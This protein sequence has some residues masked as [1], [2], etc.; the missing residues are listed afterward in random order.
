MEKALQV[1]QGKQRVEDWDGQDLAGSQF[2]LA[3]CLVAEG[4][5]DEALFQLSEV[6][7]ILNLSEPDD[8]DDLII[9]DIR[10]GSTLLMIGEVH[11]LQGRYNEALVSMHEGCGLYEQANGHE[12]HLVARALCSIALVHYEQ[13]NIS[14]ALEGSTEAL[15]L[16]IIEL[17]GADPEVERTNLIIGQIHC[18]SGEFEKGLV[19]LRQA[20][21]IERI[22]STLGDNDLDVANTLK[23]VAKALRELDKKKEALECWTEVLGIQINRLGEGHPDVADTLTIIGTLHSLMEEKSK[24]LEQ[25]GKA[26][27]IQRINNTLGDEGVDVAC[28]LTLLGKVHK[29]Q[30]KHAEALECLNEALRIER[31]R[32]G[33]EHPDVADTLTNIGILHSLMG[34]HSEALKHFGKALEIQRVTGRQVNTALVLLEVA[35]VHMLQGTFSEALEGYHGAL[36][37]QRKTLGEGHSNIGMTHWSIG[38]AHKQMG[39]HIKALKHLRKALKIQREA[40]GEESFEVA[41]VQYQIACVYSAQGLGD[42][43]KG[44]F[45]VCAKTY[46]RVCG[47]ESDRTLD[48]RR[49][50]R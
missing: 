22:N 34:E 38:T 4:R 19:H 18:N 12:H 46:A 30:D 8:P 26:L 27:E 2:L 9:R 20:L 42:R 11:S 17:G 1:Q 5:Y 16:Q 25:L 7:Q 47:P 23:L 37:L 33:E 10:I 36:D 50:A 35:G 48:A 14:A 15:R 13:C 39:Q 3:K 44:L 6:L 43:A 21:R 41:R 28:T 49:R 29:E 32:L 40:L 31:N 24:A 45:Q